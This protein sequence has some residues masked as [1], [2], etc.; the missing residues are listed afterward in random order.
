M[1]LRDTDAAAAVSDQLTSCMA[2][3]C[4][5][6]AHRSARAIDTPS[7]WDVGTGLAMTS[8]QRRECRLDAGLAEKTRGRIGGRIRRHRVHGDHPARATAADR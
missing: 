3:D 7:R 6:T 5:L 8:G 1:S 2:A 4:V